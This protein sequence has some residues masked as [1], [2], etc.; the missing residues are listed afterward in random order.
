MSKDTHKLMLDHSQAKVKLY[1]DYLAKYLKVIVQDG[2]TK[3]IHFYDL[4]CGEGIYEDGAKG[5]PIIAIDKIRSCYA[6]TEKMPK[7]EITFNDISSEVISKLKKSL[8]SSNI[9]EQ[10]EV[11][12][13]NKDYLDIRVSVIHAIQKFQKE[14][15]V[16]FLDPKGYKETSVSHIKEFLS[17]NK[18]EVLVFLPTR[19]MYRFAGMSKENITSS[20]EPL[21]QFMAEIFPKGVPEFKSQIDFI[22]K[23][24]EGLKNILAGYYVDTFTLEREPGQFFCLFFFTSNIYGLEKMLETKWEIDSEQ[25]RI[26]RYGYERNSTMFSGSEI[27]N[28]PEKLRKFI[29]SG[30]RYNRDVYNFVLHEGFLPKHANEIL[31]DWQL[32]DNLN[33]FNFDGSTG[34]KNA[35]YNTYQ[36][37]RDEPQKIYYVLNEKLKLF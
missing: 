37:Y 7:I 15:A 20:H 28:F 25:G 27:L 6:T 18:T 5:S 36:E 24:K 32:K 1:G 31:R 34:R 33:V 23:V 10:C 3:N 35:F 19:D 21:R 12:V 11:H 8:G 22:A 13:E 26:W 9:P 4:F 17:T 30:K 29:R 2:I 14:K 16:I